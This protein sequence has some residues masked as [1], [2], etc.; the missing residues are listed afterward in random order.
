MY[1]SGI[2]NLY[3]GK[4]IN[5]PFFDLIIIN[6]SNLDD[7]ELKMIYNMTKTNGKIIFL[8]KYKKIFNDS[9]KY[10][11][12]YNQKIKKDNSIY[13]FNNKY[14]AVEF[15]IMG[16]QKGGTTALATN[17]SKH[18]DIYIDGNPDPFKSEIHYFDLK[19][20]KGI[21]WYK[22][23][24]NYTKKVVGEKTPDLMYLDY[25]FP[26]IQS[27]NPYLKIILI[28]RNPIDRAYSAWNFTT[29]YFG[30]KRSF[31]LAIN[32]EL[33]N[34]LN[35]NKTFNTAATHYLQRGLYYKQIQKL[36]KWFS[37]DNLLILFSDE[38]KNNMNSEYNKVYKFLNLKLFDTKYTLEFVQNYKNNIDKDIYLQLKDFYKKDIVKLEKFT[39]KKLNWL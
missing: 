23:H 36:L 30:E 39:N 13:I 11:E 22:K 15:I 28:L 19:F 4:V 24:F 8:I 29:K 7:N 17:I 32:D 16:T 26:Y 5:P 33:D 38:V 27:I 12:N 21:E 3:D 2:F 9:K 18:P 37:K 1:N 20:N 31:K 34:K 25:T 35:E 10:N 14:R 6:H